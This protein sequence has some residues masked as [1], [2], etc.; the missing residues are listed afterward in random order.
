MH[1]VRVY[2]LI[3]YNN[4][5]LVLHEP[6]MGEL[7]Y[8]LP[9][10]GLEINEGTIDCL[11]RELNEELGSEITNISHFYTQ[12]QP[13]ISQIDH[14]TPLLF[15]YY[16]AELQSIKSL[17]I[18][19]PTI[20]QLIWCDVVELEKLLTLKTDKLVAKKLLDSSNI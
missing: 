2:G 10:G 13:I 8:K 4:K 16:H 9:G 5:Y 15:I 11:K 12:E 14:S 3:K 17:K 6:F 19:E 20:N 7:I 1:T 18:L